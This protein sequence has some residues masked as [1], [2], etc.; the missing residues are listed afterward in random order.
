MYKNQLCLG[1]AQFGLNY[2]I[3]NKLG[4]VNSEEVKKIINLAN[5][6]KINFIDT[7]QNY[8][9]A[10]NVLG[11]EVV[12]KNFKIITKHKSI[13]QKKNNEQII[14]NCENNLKTSLKRLNKQKLDTYIVHDPKDFEG[15]NKELFLNWLESIK[16]RNLT[17]RI[18]ASIYDSSDLKKL[19]LEKLDL[20]QI[21]LSI[22]NQNLYRNGS[23][24][25][26]KNLGISIHIRSIFL[27]GL[28]LVDQSE[29]PLKISKEFK[30]HHQKFIEFIKTLGYSPL[31]VTLAFCK[32]LENIECTLVGVTTKDELLQII[33]VWNNNN[34][35]EE[36]ISQIEYEKWLWPNKY[37]Y[38]PRYW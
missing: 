23:I 1:T 17:K 5:K 4:K 10:E 36:I 19:P 14:Q 22:Y 13:Y 9:E 20:I 33:N 32:N 38:D 18:G 30:Q 28:L 12:L 37:D 6:N 2:G 27:Q 21:P 25:Y 16:N 24:D 3:T 8:G 31:E 29:W 35:N 34:K 11:R 15:N 26:L 7:A